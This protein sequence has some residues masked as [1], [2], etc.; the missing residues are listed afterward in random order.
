MMG[1]SQAEVILNTTVLGLRKMDWG[2]W[3][4]ASQVAGNADLGFQEFDSVVLA[5]PY[6]FAG[7][8]IKETVWTMSRMKVW[9]G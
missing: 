5:A 7:L 8:E 3:V 2:G 1:A 4:V 6:Q 9:I